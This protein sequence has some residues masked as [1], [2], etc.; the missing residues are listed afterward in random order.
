VAGWV[1][2]GL[3]RHQRFSGL[4]R[5]PHEV[6]VAGLCLGSNEDVV[7][8]VRLRNSRWSPYQGCR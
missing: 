4:S 3:D 8:M 6:T 1:Y 2:A 5:Y 7:Q